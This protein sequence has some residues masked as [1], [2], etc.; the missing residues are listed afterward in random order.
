MDIYKHFTGTIGK[1][2]VSLDLRFGYCGGSNYGGSY[3][4]EKG[5]N[6]AKLLI[7]GEPEKFE[8]DATL[9]AT[10]FPI[11]A[12]WMAW[13]RDERHQVATWVFTIKDDRL[14]GKWQ[15]KD[16]KQRLD[17]KLVEEYS[18]AV[19]MEM[20]DYRDSVKK[21]LGAQKLSA[22]YH[23]IGVK[24][25]SKVTAADADFIN[26]QLLALMVGDNAGAKTF[27]DAPAAESHICF[28]EFRK[29][30]QQ[31]IS[32][33]PT[34]V[35]S[36]FLEERYYSM[37]FPIYNGDGFL[38]MECT[39]FCRSSASGLKTKN[40][41]S[42]I[43]VAHKKV[44]HLNDVVADK[45]KL[46]ELLWDS[47]KASIQAN[48]RV[49]LAPEKIAPVESMILTQNGLVFCDPS[50]DDMHL[51]DETRIFVPYEKLDKVLTTEFKSRMN[52]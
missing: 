44:W 41:Y 5:S 8:Y 9:T 6:D 25:S 7:I 20:V 21:Y 15:S 38:V 37:L 52:L 45:T 43:D 12:D 42:C 24:P 47:Y 31:L 34:K 40:P 39:G 48:A 32:D 50:G 46:T 2:K 22:T 30:C 35:S 29:D 28:E 51:N 10:E 18:N 4:F 3:Y 27:S 1:R 26:S 23:F 11:G 33:T 49:V 17:I 16:K 14:T 13:D 36:T 19:P